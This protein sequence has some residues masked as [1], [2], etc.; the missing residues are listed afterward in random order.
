V[1]F[2]EVQRAFDERH[3]LSAEEV[4]FIKLSCCIVEVSTI[5]WCILH[6]KNGRDIHK[7]ENDGRVYYSERK[8]TILK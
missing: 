5:P 6:M 2:R 8:L 3:K 7:L 1:L 4:W